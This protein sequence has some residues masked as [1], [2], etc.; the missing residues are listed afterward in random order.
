MYRE[1][2]EL[3]SSVGTSGSSEPDSE[4]K[5]PT[6]AETDLDHSPGHPIFTER[7]CTGVMLGEPNLVA[8]NLPGSTCSEQ[9]CPALDSQDGTVSTQPCYFHINELN[10]VSITID[11][12]FLGSFSFSVAI[13]KSFW[14][15]MQ[16]SMSLYKLIPHS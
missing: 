2:L 14:E 1:K 5:T 9:S 3:A 8:F 11:F 15:K 13:I 12:N 16:L 6:W 7:P 4:C 10:Q